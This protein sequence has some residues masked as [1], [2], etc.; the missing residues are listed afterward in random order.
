MFKTCYLIYL[1]SSSRDWGNYNLAI[2]VIIEKKTYTLIY[3]DTNNWKVTLLITLSRLIHGTESNEIILGDT[4]I[5][6]QWHR[7]RTADH[8]IHGLVEKKR[9]PSKIY[10]IIT[11]I[12]SLKLVR[13]QF[14]KMVPHLATCCLIK[15][16][17][18]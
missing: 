2:K 1:N 5:Y 9:A 17:F 6:K 7:L 18:F 4:L 11:F 16:F 13:V 8:T 12:Y 3:C 10:W 14:L 15:I